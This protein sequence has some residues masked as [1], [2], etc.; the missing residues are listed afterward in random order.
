ML[1]NAALAIEPIYQ[2]TYKTDGS[3]EERA[4]VNQSGWAY[5]LAAAT[6]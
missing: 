6:E 3:G 5:I 2:F 1:D 4:T